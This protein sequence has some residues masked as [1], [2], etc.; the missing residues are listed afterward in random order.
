MGYE[1]EVNFVRFV[2]HPLIKDCPIQILILPISIICYSISFILFLLIYYLFLFPL[3]FS[4]IRVS[5]KK[6]SEEEGISPVSICIIGGRRGSG[7]I[8]PFIRRVKYLLYDT[9]NNIGSIYLI[10][11]L[12]SLA[13]KLQWFNDYFQKYFLDLFYKM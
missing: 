8:E 12:F 6:Q 11:V 2:I 1:L 13:Y 7:V 5:L 4:Q 3:V 10:S 9:R